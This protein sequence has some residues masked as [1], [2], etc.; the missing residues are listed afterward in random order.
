MGPVAQPDFINAVAQIDT[1]LAPD[2]LL[3]E[4]LHIERLHGRVRGLRWGPRTLDLDLLIY[5]QEV[6]CTPRLQ[7]PHPGVVQRNFVL[8]PLA[9]LA[10]DLD[11]PGYGSVRSLME[12]VSTTGLERIL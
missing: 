9:E 6:I 11:I 8:L 4:L 1:Y 7:V 2:I 3:G 5:G 10:P 12:K